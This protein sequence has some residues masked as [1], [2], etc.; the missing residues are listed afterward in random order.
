MQDRGLPSEV[1]GL[2]ADF[3]AR[4]RPV[5]DA[6]ALYVGGSL[7]TGDYHPGVSDV[8]LVAVVERP[9][10]FRQRQLLA[11]VH[12]ALIARHPVAALL[13]CV[14]VPYGT[15]PDAGLRHPT[16]TGRILLRRRFT[17]IARA[18][19]HRFGFAVFGVA[20]Q[21][22]I[23]AVTD[24]E[25][26]QGVRRELTDYWAMALQQHW[27]WL[28]DFD[29]D[30]SLLTLARAQATLTEGTLIT[31]R[32]ALARLDRFGVPP[33]LVTEIGLRRDAHPSALSPLTRLRRAI[34]VHRLVSDGIDTLLSL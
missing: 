23:P 26:R 18:E 25:L 34:Q 7:A 27:I 22:V 5:A 10:T 29:I 31:K 19:V 3:A 4:M 12:R 20:P 32:E 24:D 14:Y 9:L 6:V 28:R 11:G 13:H 15:L 16:W 1:D 33:E 17:V 8:D 2:L 30:L 21:T